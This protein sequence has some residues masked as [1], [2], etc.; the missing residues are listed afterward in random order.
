VCENMMVLKLICKIE[1]SHEQ[2]VRVVTLP[3]TMS[4]PAFRTVGAAKERHDARDKVA[5]RMIYAADWSMPGMLHAKVVRS[6]YPSAR[7]VSIDDTE[8]RAIPG[9]SAVIL[10]KDVP[11]NYIE[12]DPSGMGLLY[13]RQPVLAFERVRYHGEAVAVVVGETEEAAEAGAEALEVD[14]ESLPGVFSPHEA[15][16]NGA[17]LVHEEGNLLIEWKLGK[18][19]PDEIWDR[20]DVVVENTYQS[21]WVDHAYLEPEAGVAW[22]D[23]DGLVTIRCSTQVV[24]HF[25]EIAHVLQLPESKVRVIG[26]YLG[27][28]FGGKEDMTVELF[29]A[30]ATWKTRKP[31]RMVWSRQESLTARPKRH[32][33]TMKYRTGATRDGKLIAQDIDIVADAGAYPYL[34]GRVLLAGSLV[35]VGPYMVPN[36]SV[37][38]RAI[39]TN[40][41]PTSAF[42]GFG[43]MQVVLAYEGQMD[44]IAKALKMDPREVRRLNY[45][46]Q[47]EEMGTG[48]IAPTY[49]A[50]VE[51]E[52]LAIEALGERTRPSGPNKAVGRSFAASGFPIGRQI[53]WRDN[54]SAWVGFEPD[55]SLAIRAGVPD[56]GGGQ[57]SSLIQIASEVLGVPM[58]QIVIHIS[59]SA[60]TPLTGGTF[61]TRQLQMSGNAVLKASRELADKLLGFAA[62]LLGAPV[63]DLS[64]APNQ[65]LVKNR[66]GDSLPLKKLIAE[67][68]KTGEQPYQHSTFV[69]VRDENRF[70]LKTGRGNAY[71]DFTY[72]VH[73][74]EVEVDLETGH[75]K[76]L[77]YTACHD[78][79][80]AINPQS[81]VG[82]IQGGAA[83]GIGYALMEEIQVNEGINQTGLFS[84]YLIPTSADLP[85]IQA[86]IFESGEGAGPF[87]ARGIGE[88][89]LA[90]TAAAIAAAIE[91]AV[92]VRLQH[93]PF[94]PERVL[95]AISEGRSSE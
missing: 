81:V 33:F 91:D 2:G 88:P 74:T 30:L 53:W 61:A 10:A 83:M 35:S 89:A 80:R 58:E 54:A 47:G 4:K 86:L 11:Q 93:L 76:V 46:K 55:G 25:R 66:P 62:G 37:Y 15:M 95:K 14:Y 92:G 63:E 34:S 31:V 59:D 22:I 50:L 49:V 42:R 51:V 27:G 43:A 16:E 39:Y 40:N 29:L 87:G 36:T 65:V 5:G 1:Y 23:T 56:L 71:A 69:M 52:A 45:I 70:D 90:N 6:P 18:G 77:K 84:S 68:R 32:P 75:V 28:G 79:G 60:L 38:S 72:G 7:I 85:D 8:A 78:I 57:A 19:L 17:P 41:V 20:C 13:R 94:S 67:Y 21:Q 26:A 9:V 48:Q 64:L 3:E 73:A 24:E 44:A 12:E 82:Q